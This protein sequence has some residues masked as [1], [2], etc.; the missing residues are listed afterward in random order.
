MTNNN[1]KTSIATPAAAG[2]TGHADSLAYI[3]LAAD[4]GRSFTDCRNAL[5][6]QALIRGAKQS[7][8]V[9]GT[10]VDKGDVSRIAKMVGE[11][12]K[13][14]STRFAGSIVLAE[15]NLDDFDA[16][17]TIAKAGQR[18]RRVKVSKAP[19]AGTVNGKT[20]ES[21]D[22]DYRAMIHDF[23]VNA[24]DFE[25]AI[26]VVMEAVEAARVTLTEAAAAADAA[27]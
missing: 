15:L 8:I 22:T 10:G 26:A 2:P 9:A 12:T 19:A 17:A 16:V 18:F 6:A 14:A 5:I 13:A 3:K 4:R 25:A 1:R 23:I 24:P 20:G 21:E 7:E 27:A 11:M